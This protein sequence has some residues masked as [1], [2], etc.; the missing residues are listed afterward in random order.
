MSEL[1][2][3]WRVQRKCHTPRKE[4]YHGEG[5]IGECRSCDMDWREDMETHGHLHWR[6]YD[7]DRKKRYRDWDKSMN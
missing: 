2:M 5:L 7:R 3:S 4:I 6:S 1:V